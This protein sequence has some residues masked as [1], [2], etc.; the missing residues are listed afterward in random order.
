MTREQ[1]R[2]FRDDPTR[3]VEAGK[4]EDYDTGWIAGFD[5]P[6]IAIVSWDSGVITSYPISKLR[7]KK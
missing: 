2:K 1:A 3:R 6:D 4:G 7:P 5:G